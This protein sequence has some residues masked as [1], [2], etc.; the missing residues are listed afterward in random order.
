MR[1]QVTYAI[2]LKRNEGEFWLES[3]TYKGDAIP[4]IRPA[5]RVYLV[6]KSAVLDLKTIRRNGKEEGAVLVRI[7]RRELTREDM[8]A[9]GDAWSRM[10]WV[11][12]VGDAN[13]HL[14][15]WDGKV[16][17]GRGG[18][19]SIFPEKKAAEAF[20]SG[21]LSG[22][23]ATVCQVQITPAFADEGGS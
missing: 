11:V 1:E 7:R 8:K 10:G 19:M 4:A 20:V 2:R 21:I 17:L 23:N 9:R 16:L 13:F 18:E 6:R 14:V 12:R 22:M 15:A 3:V 5:R